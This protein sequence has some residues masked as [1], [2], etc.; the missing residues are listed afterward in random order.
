MKVILLSFSIEDKHCRD[1]VD[2]KSVEERKELFSY[3]LYSC[4]IC[5]M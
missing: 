5:D 1:I 2:A 3:L 4:F